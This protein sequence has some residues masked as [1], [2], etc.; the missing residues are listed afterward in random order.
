MLNNNATN[1]HDYLCHVMFIAIF[2]ILF[3]VY[4]YLC[5]YCYLI[6]LV[7]NKFCFYYFFFTPMIKQKATRLLERII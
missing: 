6:L 7:V 1:F 4:S 2:F 3:T 5:T